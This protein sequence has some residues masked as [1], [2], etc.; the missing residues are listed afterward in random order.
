MPKILFVSGWYPTDE[1]PS[2][3]IFVKRHAQAAALS[4]TVS[5]LYVHTISSAERNIIRMKTTA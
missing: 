4:N 5:V 1:N 2:H 3:G